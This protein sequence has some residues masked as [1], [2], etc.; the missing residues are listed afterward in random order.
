VWVDRWD[1]PLLTLPDTAAI[2]DCLITK[3]VPAQRTAAAARTRPTPLVATKRGA[4][5][6]GRND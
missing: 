6:I 4:L 5:I 1:A 2:T 3:F